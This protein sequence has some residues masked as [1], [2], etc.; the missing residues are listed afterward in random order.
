MKRRSTARSDGFTL[1][2]LM[3]V[4]AI[5]A[6]LM[7][8]AAPAYENWVINRQVAA[9]AESIHFA[10]LR[11][12]AEAVR[13]NARVVFEL[14]PGTSGGGTWR[15]GLERDNGAAGASATPDWFLTEP[16]PGTHTLIETHGA[17]TAA[18]VA[19]GAAGG[20]SGSGSGSGADAAGA[21]V[22]ETPIR[23][24][25]TGLGMLTTASTTRRFDFRAARQPGARRL[26]V[27]LPLGGA[28]RL[29]NP[30]LAAASGSFAC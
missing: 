26:A 14:V 8:G 25:Y 6:V 28:P 29:C 9:T 27:L 18:N 7:L 2:E 12:R 16:L 20:G 30:A 1:L 15:L 23:V 17:G 13:R 11:A 3:I 19:S 24:T 22:A 21:T 10:L 4:L 5:G